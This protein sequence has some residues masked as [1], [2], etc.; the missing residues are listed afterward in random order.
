[1]RGI[2]EIL[3]SFTI[4]LAGL[5]TLTWMTRTEIVERRQEQSPP[6]NLAG[7]SE[8]PALALSWGLEQIEAPQAWKQEKG[9]WKRGPNA[10]TSAYMDR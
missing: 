2:N 6:T 8:D 1:M 4:G 5:A 9:N 7:K 10:F 3:L